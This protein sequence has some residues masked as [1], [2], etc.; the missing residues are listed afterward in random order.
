MSKSPGT[1]KLTHELQEI[2]EKA[3]YTVIKARQEAAAM[4]AQAGVESPPAIGWFGSRC[5]VPGCGCTNYTGD[6][7]PCLS[8]VT[9]DPGASPPGRSCGHRPSQHRE[10]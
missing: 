5:G 8:P 4:L 7:C 6:G 1:E 10:T 9:T 2:L 3:A